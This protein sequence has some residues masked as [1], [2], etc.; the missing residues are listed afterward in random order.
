MLWLDQVCVKE[1]QSCDIYQTEYDLS[2]LLGKSFFIVTSKL[3]GFGYLRTTILSCFHSTHALK[4]TSHLS[5]VPPLIYFRAKLTTAHFLCLPNL[6]FSRLATVII[7]HGLPFSTILIICIYHAWSLQLTSS[8]QRSN[9]DAWV[10]VC[11]LA[12]DHFK[13]MIWKFSN[14]SWIYTMPVFWSLTYLRHC[15]RVVDA[16]VHRNCPGCQV[17]VL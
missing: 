2:Y 12:N 3:T 15:R 9:D 10:W 5:T 7:I 16:Q 11:K 1:H 8:I 13:F 17:A 6:P 4:S 14:I